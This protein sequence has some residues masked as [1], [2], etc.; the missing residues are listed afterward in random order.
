MNSGV[1]SGVN[2]E[3]LNGSFNQHKI[4]RAAPILKAEP[5]VDGEY[6]ISSS[7]NYK[8]VFIPTWNNKPEVLPSVVSLS[9]TPIL[10]F[11][12]TSAIIA[13][14]GM[15]KSSICEAICSSYLNPDADSLY[16]EVDQSC[17]GIVYVDNERTNTDV[18]NSF[19]RICRR[20]A[21]KEGEELKKV[22]IAGLR[23]VPRLAE[24][25]ESI[26]YLLSNHEC[27]LL[28][29]DGAGDLV[30]DT[31]DLMEAAE[32][33]IWL[34]ELTVKYKI[35]VLTTIHPNPN[36]NKPRGHIGSE[37]IRESECVLLAKLCADDVRIITSDFEHGKNRN[38]PKLTTA[39]KWSDEQSMFVSANT[40]SAPTKQS[41]K[42]KLARV[43]AENLA[44]KVLS[45]PTALR[46]TDLV[47]KIMQ[48]L[49]QT[50]STAKRARDNML[51]WK[52]IK[53]FDDGL[54]RTII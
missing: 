28:L 47:D 8:N 26:E 53:K 1:R 29:L 11:Q 10:T 19:Y 51:A 45:P 2:E 23:S 13:N 16:F 14:P 52:I 24:R 18:W 38:N 17:K 40:E 3:M 42:D 33:R 9:G 39:Y 7:D 37:I 31:N 30:T 4:K 34:R 12:N 27:S 54:Y 48:A 43:E 15:G 20:A 46:Y 6:Q 25:K 50:E 22:K 36:S 5:F 41:K 32:C 21:I 35:S 44:L 49:N